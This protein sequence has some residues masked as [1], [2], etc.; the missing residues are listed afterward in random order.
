MTPRT[1][2]IAAA[3]HRLLFLKHGMLQS[4]DG[5]NLMRRESRRRSLCER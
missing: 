2:R 4:G 1:G 5:G 3:G